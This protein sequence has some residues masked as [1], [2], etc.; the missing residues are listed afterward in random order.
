MLGAAALTAPDA[1]A[2]AARPVAAVTPADAPT[3]GGEA[4]GKADGTA[5]QCTFDDEFD[6]STLDTDNWVPQLM[7]NSQYTTGP[8]GSQACYVD[9]ST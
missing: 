2:Q 9:E 8:T 1:V 5:W 4:P 7:A 6:G 3:C